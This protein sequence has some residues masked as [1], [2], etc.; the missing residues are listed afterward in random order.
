MPRGLV[1]E[2]LC[3][4]ICFHA[5][6]ASGLRAQSLRSMFPMLRATRLA[7]GLPS[8]N[9]SACRQT[10]SS[11]S[12]MREVVAELVP[13]LCIA[14]EGSGAENVIWGPIPIVSTE[15]SG[16][17][18]KEG[19]VICQQPVHAA[20]LCIYRHL[21]KAHSRSRCSSDPARVTCAPTF[22]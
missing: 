17:C 4:K 9:M 2:M 22:S 14:F 15:T 8:S 5:G 20:A 16:E 7:Y 19:T 1:A 12:S 11:S 21:I 13:A 10:S 3:P 18:S 6:G